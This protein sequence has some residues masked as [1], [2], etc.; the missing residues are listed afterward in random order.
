[1]SQNSQ[2]RAEY[3]RNQEIQSGHYLLSSRNR[4]EIQTVLQ[5]PSQN[6]PDH[7]KS[8]GMTNNP[9]IFTNY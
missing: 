9:L 7:R 3:P 2:S 8:Y 5:T 4:P 1:M 6:S